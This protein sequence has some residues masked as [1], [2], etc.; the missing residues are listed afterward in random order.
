MFQPP[1]G[2]LLA[3]GGISGLDHPPGPV[4]DCLGYLYRVSQR[5]AVGECSR[6]DNSRDIE[7]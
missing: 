2:V 4:A 7:W 5:H 6:V 1:I 3:V